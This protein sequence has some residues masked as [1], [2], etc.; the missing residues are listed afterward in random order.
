MGFY[1]IFRGLQFQNGLS[2]SKALDADSYDVAN[3]VTIKIPM[4]IPYMPDQLD[5]TR[6]TGKF[7]HNGE[8]FRKVKQK[9]AQDTLT[10]VC[11]KDI[12]HKKIDLAITKF[13]KT[14]V[15]KPSESNT[16]SKVNVTFLKDY[17]PVAFEILPHAEGWILQVIQARPSCNLN[18]SFSVSIIQPPE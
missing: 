15:E 2:L 11:V 5:F 17:L 18:S 14:F 3:S 10:V 4:S 13:V 12:V 9:Y 8:L 16:S 1:G 7:E 6:I